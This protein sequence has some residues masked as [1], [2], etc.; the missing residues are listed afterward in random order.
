MVVSKCSYIFKYVDLEVMP[1]VSGSNPGT[2][3]PEM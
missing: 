3:F 2:G 1:S